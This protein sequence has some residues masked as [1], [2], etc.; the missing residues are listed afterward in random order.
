MEVKVAVATAAWSDFVP[1]AL[2]NGRQLDTAVDGI[3]TAIEP[4]GVMRGSFLQLLYILGI[5]TVQFASP[6]QDLG[7][8]LPSWINT[9]DKGE[10]YKAATVDPI[11]YQVR[12]Y[13]SPMWIPD[14]GGAGP[15]VHCPRSAPSSG[16]F[17]AD[18]WPQLATGQATLTSA[19]PRIVDSRGGRS[20]LEWATDPAPFEKDIGL[21]FPGPALPS[22]A[23]QLAYE[24]GNAAK[25]IPLPGA[26]ACRTIP[27]GQD[28]GVAVYD[29]SP[30]PAPVTMIG[31]PTVTATIATRDGEVPGDLATKLWDVDEAAGRQSLVTKGVYRL[32][33]NQS[34]PVTLQ[35]NG[36]AWT[37]QPGHHA[38]LEIAGRDDATWR[39]SNDDAFTVTVSALT[40][41]LPTR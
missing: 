39:P 21:P 37:F 11:W 28:S 25:I 40:L 5:A 17:D 9:F 23:T 16:P 15:G 18:S 33:P 34:G 31:L 7:A 12:R 27:V 6:Q 13:R 19:P 1:A 32:E 24:V 36:G 22:A 41:T 8:V 29:L 20:D 4:T 35:L 10:P 26:E 2:N 3:T 14:V 30:P 38:H